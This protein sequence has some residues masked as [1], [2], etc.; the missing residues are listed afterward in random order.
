[1]KCYII[2]YDLRSP[3]RNYDGLYEG[4]KSYGTWGKL[5]QSTWA[6]VTTETAVQ[7]RDYLSK[8]IDSNDRIFVVKSGKE[9]AWKNV[10]A[11]SEWLKKHLN[12]G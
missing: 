11:G 5:T 4:I 7:V 8:Y 3:G 9:A 1:M 6:I 10:R 12:K 2:T